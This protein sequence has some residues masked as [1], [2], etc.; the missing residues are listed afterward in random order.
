M[1]SKKETSF[2]PIIKKAYY[3]NQHIFRLGVI[4]VFMI[5]LMSILRPAL[6]FSTSCFSS[7]AFQIPTLGLFSIAMMFTI[8]S[9]GIDMSI[10]GIANICGI[11]TAYIMLAINGKVEGIG[12]IFIIILA[13]VLCI[14]I[15]GVLGA[16]NGI[17][18]SKFKI[19]PML[20]TLGTMYLY[21]GIGI[22]LTEGKTLS[23]FPTEY[24]K[25]GTGTIGFIPIPLIILIIA[26]LI[27][28]I[29]L[30]KTR[31]GYELKLYGTSPIASQYSGIRNSRI[32]IRTYM[33]SGIM[34][35]IAGVLF[36]ASAN[37]AKAEYGSVY[38]FNSLL[39]AILGG[40]NPNGGEGKMSGLLLSLISLQVLATGF[41]MLRISSTLSDFVWGALLLVVLLLNALSDKRTL[42]AKT[43]K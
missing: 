10:V 37:S 32:V 1:N 34:C 43:S 25:I 16:V 29:I 12:L 5:A 30:N 17:I 15:G 39:C 36:A 13:F 31:F 23:G 24:A 33:Y 3:E 26:F 27:S 11:V 20:T 38:M 7:I 22:G 40:T 4:L 42:K 18:I 6:F 28:F 41:N 14:V 9:G 8:I 21:T 19:P 2:S 35:G